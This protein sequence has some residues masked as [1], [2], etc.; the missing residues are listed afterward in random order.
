MAFNL[1]LAFKVNGGVPPSAKEHA[2]QQA[3]AERE[4]RAERLTAA[5]LAEELAMEEEGGGEWVTVAGAATAGV[6]S[7]A[8]DGISAAAETPAA[9]SKKD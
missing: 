1:A 9:K 3:K 5:V 8:N 6:A 4:Q 7:S 2:A